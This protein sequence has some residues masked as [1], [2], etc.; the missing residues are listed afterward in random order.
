MS[1]IPGALLDNGLIHLNS[2]FSV[3]ET[4][5]RIQ[6]VLTGR[7]LKIFCLIDHSGEAEK[8][9]LEMRPTKLI[10]FGSPM[11]GTPVMIASPTSAIDLPLKALVWQDA[12]KKVFVSFNSPEYLQRR[13]NV[14]IELIKNI[15]AAGALLELAVK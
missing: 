15:S 6:S 11:A 14:P 9:G 7:G 13:H 2:S 8:A 10:L 12:N 5:D 4:L 3:E 1:S